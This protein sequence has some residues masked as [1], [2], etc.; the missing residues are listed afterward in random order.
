MKRCPC[1][2]LWFTQGFRFPHSKHRGQ[3]Q[4]KHAFRAGRHSRPPYH[5]HDTTLKP[6]VCMLAGLHASAK[7][8]KTRASLSAVA[9]CQGL[10]P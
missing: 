9:G 5:A 7:P 2:P 3:H 1:V 8:T 6:C 4:I 10:P